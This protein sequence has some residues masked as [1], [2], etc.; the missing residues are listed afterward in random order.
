MRNSEHV[1][2]KKVEQRPR[3]LGHNFVQA[4]LVS[5]RLKHLSYRFGVAVLNFGLNA[6]RVFQKCL[7]KLS[8]RIGKKIATHREKSTQ[9]NFAQIDK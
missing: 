9:I 2:S 7:K 6:L 5:V 1:E 8:T 3:P 4:Q